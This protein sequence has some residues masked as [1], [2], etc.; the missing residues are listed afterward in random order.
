MLERLTDQLKSSGAARWYAAKEPRERLTF[1]ALAIVAL[2]VFLWAG[3][4][5][6]LADWQRVQSN[7]LGN[8][9][10]LIEWLQ[11]N[12]SRARAALEEVTDEPSR[13]ILP[14][15]TRAAEARGL[16]VGRLQPESDGVVSVTLQGQPFNDLI[17]WVA[18]L[19]DAEGITVIRASIDAQETAGLV[20]AQLRLR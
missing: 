11:A 14:I 9:E 19:E 18:A 10:D 13:S 7:R 5:R 6:P 17:A 1:G 8:A 15:I 4:W 12:E 3:M 2:L 20:N 16:K